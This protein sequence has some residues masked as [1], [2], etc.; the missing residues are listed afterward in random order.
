MEYGAKYSNSL[1]SVNMHTNISLI[2][3]KDLSKYTR[4][5]LLVL[6]S[7][8]LPS[9]YVACVARAAALALE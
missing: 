2:S 8:I 3:N 6:K 4:S 7:E 1:Q 5:M 9:N